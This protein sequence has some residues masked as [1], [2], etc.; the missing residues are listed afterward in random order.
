[1]KSHRWWWTTLGLLVAVIVTLLLEPT[2]T[3]PGWLAGEPFHG[4][5]PASWWQDQLLNG[6]PATQGMPD[7]DDR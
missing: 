4:N 7:N 6:D 5:R 2:R 1:M 3:V